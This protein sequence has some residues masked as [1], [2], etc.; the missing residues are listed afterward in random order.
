MAGMSDLYKAI[1]RNSSIGM[2]VVQSDGRILMHNPAFLELSQ[3]QEGSLPEFIWDLMVPDDRAPSRDRFDTLV[4]PGERYSW[5][6]HIES[7]RHPI[8]W[9]LDVSVVSGLDGKPLR[10]VNTRD[11]TLQR[12]TEVRL[13]RAKD[14]AERATRTKSA[15]LANMSHE[16]RTP[17]HTVTG[18][19]ELLLQTQLDEEQNEYANQVRFAADV[20]L[21]LINDILD[22]S[23]IE[24]GKLSLEEIDYPLVHTTEE[25]VDMV[26]LEAHKKGIEVVLSIGP[27]VPVKVVGDP[28]RLRQII[29]NLFNNAVK[30]TAAGGEIEIRVAV[31]PE[32]SDRTRVRF[33][34]RDTGIGI[35][36]DKVGK[37]FS[38]F[39]QVDSSTTRKFGGTGLGLSISQ[40]LVEMMKGAIGVESVEGEGSTFWF[41]IPF[42]VVEPSLGDDPLAVGKRVLLVDDNTTSSSVVA[43]YLER[44]GADV[45]VVDGG[46][47]ALERLR[48]AVSAETA[49]DLALLDLELKGMDG[50]QLAGEIH[51]DESISETALILL[52]P[53][54]LMAREAKMKRL[55]WF[56]GYARKPVSLTELESEIAKAL[57]ADEISPQEVEELEDDPTVEEV[58]PVS[59]RIVVAEDHLIN[60]TL[61]RAI[62]DKL[63]HQV[64][65]AADGRAAVEAVEREAPDLVFMDVQMPEMNGYEATEAIRASGFK[66]PIVAVTANATRSE[67]ERCFEAGMDDFLSKPFKRDDIV[68]IL[69]KWV[70]GSGLGDTPANERPEA[71]EPVYGDPGFEVAEDLIGGGLTGVGAA[72]FSFQ[73][74][75]TRFGG[76]AEIVSRVVEQFA[77]KCEQIG[78]VLADALAEEDFDKVQLEAH[79]LKGGARNL[80]ALPVGD[81]AALLEGSAKLQ[82]RDRCEHYLSALGPRLAEFVDV[83]REVISE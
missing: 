9:Q 27:G 22:F 82:D 71:T 59:V 76:N 1:F 37:L 48:T 68:P 28:G 55:M 52:S 51:N 23:K 74:A 64:Y 73:D 20:L 35:P 70:S 45:D 65:L 79:G 57:S 47:E 25:A 30:F 61:F 2:A 15:F 56:R 39:T 77:E 13:K 58:A 4:H 80:E 40:S 33:E 81:A 5:L 31:V 50:W 7:K 42:V 38:A 11:V 29:V 63:G 69:D 46:Q 53:S 12:N 78:D 10:L 67:R 17:I 3:R 34:V 43:G 54:G 41:E 19:T 60:Q 83:A 32:S 21:Y 49:Y 6:V 62:L 14:A 8:L 18:M 26:S 75:V 36:A 16:I 72:V 44:W 66:G 24:A